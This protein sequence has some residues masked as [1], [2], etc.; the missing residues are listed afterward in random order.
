MALCAVLLPTWRS[1]CMTGPCWNV[2]HTK[3]AIFF[4]K[5][6]TCSFTLHTEQHGEVQGERDITV[7]S[8]SA[9]F[10]LAPFLSKINSFSI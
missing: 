9:Y 3:K 4:L 10:E 7:H 1:V 8:N 5:Y 2:G 6:H